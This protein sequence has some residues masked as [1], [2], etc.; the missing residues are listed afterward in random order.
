M[1][2]RV[3]ADWKGTPVKHGQAID[4][5]TYV[6]DGTTQGVS[7][8]LAEKDAARGKAKVDEVVKRFADVGCVVRPPTF[9]TEIDCGDW[10]VRVKY[11]D[12]TEDVVVD[13]AR[14]ATRCM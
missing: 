1:T 9:R 13:A 3:T 7:I 8:H 6:F 10:D 4:P 14:K 12:I 5:S 2:F 11:S